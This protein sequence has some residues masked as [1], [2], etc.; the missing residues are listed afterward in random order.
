MGNAVVLSL[1]RSPL[2][3][4]FRGLGE[5]EF[6]GRRSG[7]VVRLPVQ[8]A[9]DAH[10]VVVNVGHAAGKRWWRNFTNPHPVRVHAGGATLTGIG[11]V[12]H[13]SDADRTEAERVYRLRYPKATLSTNDPIVLIEPAPEP[14]AG[15]DCP[16]PGSP[17][18][19]GSG[20]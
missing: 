9:R 19:G 20:W 11:R 10:R 16:R 5:L 7:R 4:L 2:G 13:V 12:V 3:R 1:L 18:G 14:G 8:Y 17:P 15:E 6:T